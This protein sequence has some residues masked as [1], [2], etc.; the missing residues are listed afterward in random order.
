LIVR[1]V[2]SP[3][4]TSPHSIHKVPLPSFLVC[5]LNFKLIYFF[6]GCTVYNKLVT[7]ALKYTPVVLEHHIPYKTL[8][9]GKLY[10]PPPSYLPTPTNPQPKS[11]KPPIQTHTQKTLQKLILS[12]FHNTIHILSQLTEAKMVVL[13]LGESA[14]VVPYVVGSRKAVRAYLK[15]RIS[16]LGGE[17]WFWSRSYTH[18]HTHSL[19]PSLYPCLCAL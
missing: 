5:L 7:T 14:R 13:A 4:T 15:V 19:S 3:F 8:P 17:V 18:I 12:Y 1:L 10:V 11:S 6:R 9:N 2:R 16:F